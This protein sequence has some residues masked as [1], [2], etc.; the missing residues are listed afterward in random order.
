M[1]EVDLSGEAYTAMRRSSGHAI[2]STTVRRCRAPHSGIQL[3]ATQ[4]PA[5]ANHPCASWL[6]IAASASAMACSKASSVRAAFARKNV[7]TLDQ[8][9]SIG[10]KSGEYGGR[11]G[12]AAPAAAPAF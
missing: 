3:D 12:S 8:H 7:L 5:W 6:V 2:G 1:V 11:Y 10:E 4:Y 9:S